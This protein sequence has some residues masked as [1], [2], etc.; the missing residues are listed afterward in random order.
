MGKVSV[1]GPAVNIFL[2]TLLFGGALATVTFA[3]DLSVVL[4]LAAFLNG[5]MAV[6]NL[7]PIGILDG[8]LISHA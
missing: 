6:F 5:Y 1:A 8:F 7:I 2:S 4:L 3:A